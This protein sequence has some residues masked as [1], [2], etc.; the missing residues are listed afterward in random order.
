MTQPKVIVHIGQ[1]K[2]GST[3]IQESLA[4]SRSELVQHG[5]LYPETLYISGRH[6]WLSLLCRNDVNRANSAVWRMGFDPKVARAR[7]REEWKNLC[8]QIEVTAPAQLILSSEM[9][10]RAH[11]EVEV[12]RAQSFVPT[13]SDDIRVMAY[14]RSPVSRYL[15]IVQQVLKSRSQIPPPRDGG[16]VKILECYKAIYGKPVEVRPFER[17][18]LL[19]GDVV[20]DFAQWADLRVPSDAIT[21]I[22]SNVSVSAEA[23]SVLQILAPQYLPTNEVELRTKRMIFNAVSRADRELEGPTKPALKSEIAEII[24]KSSD[25][26]V[27]LDRKYDLRFND[28]DYDIVGTSA[29]SEVEKVTLVEQICDFDEM[30]RDEVLERTR[31]YLA[32]KRKRSERKESANARKEAEAKD[33]HS[34]WS[35]LMD[36]LKQSR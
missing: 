30:R 16:S 14:I 27:E 31:K 12:R 25:E 6:H 7:A 18:A 35:R 3:A 28:I 9:L 1:G 2:A 11:S 34:V 20:R 15:S 29:C 32:N 4:A 8:R 21:N 24:M 10:F 23:M 33:V 26:L 36:S 19:D 13:L 17:S 5:C 22:T